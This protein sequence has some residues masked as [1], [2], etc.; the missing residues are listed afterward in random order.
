MDPEKSSETSPPQPEQGADKKQEVEPPLE[1]EDLNQQQKQTPQGENEGEDKESNPTSSH[2]PTLNSLPSPPSVPAKEEGAGLGLG[3]KSFL[4]NL[5]KSLDPLAKEFGK[6]FRQAVQFAGEKIGTAEITPLPQEYFELENRVD[7]LR[8][9]YENLILVAAHQIQPGSGTEIKFTVYNTLNNVIDQV[10]AEN[11]ANVHNT[12]RSISVSTNTPNHLLASAF[13]SSASSLPEDSQLAT[14]LKKSGEAQGKIGQSRVR[15]NIEINNKFINKLST[16]LETTFRNVYTARRLVL[17]SRMRL[18]AIKSQARSASPVEVES[19]SDDLQFAQNEFNSQ[20]SVS[21]DLMKLLLNS[22]EA[23]LA[24]TEFAH[25]MLNYF[26]EG[27]D[28]LSELTPELDAIHSSMEKPQG[29]VEI[30]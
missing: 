24:L 14:A 26:K 4:G 25:S 12:L 3:A 16:S 21:T 22:P 15:M 20:V 7:R 30:V 23:V 27:F 6:N 1:N 19:L 28:I 17:S 5:K 8:M 9:I 10:G 18:D 2:A 29:S 13:N 11:S